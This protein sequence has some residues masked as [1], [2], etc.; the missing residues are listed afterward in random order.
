M[1]LAGSVLSDAF[2]GS[3]CSMDNAISCDTG[4]VIDHTLA[5][6]ADMLVHGRRYSAVYILGCIQV[7]AGFVVANL[8]DKCSCEE[9]N[10]NSYSASSMFQD[11]GTSLVGPLRQYGTLAAGFVSC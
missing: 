7:F 5:M 2:M 4:Y 8:S 9:D 6:I 10:P 11:T 1:D 3:F